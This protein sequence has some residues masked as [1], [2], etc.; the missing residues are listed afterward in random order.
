MRYF[1]IRSEIRSGARRRMAIPILI[2]IL[3]R[4]L[5][6]PGR[7]G[8]WSVQS[9]SSSH[10]FAEG[11]PRVP[12][13]VARTNT[14]RARHDSSEVPRMYP[15]F[16]LMPGLWSLDPGLQ[17]DAQVVSL[18]GGGSLGPGFRALN[19]TKT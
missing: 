5:S 16:P 12:F 19:R 9:T 11:R 2:L 7:R 18:T 4:I 14:T 15:Q 13:M 6:D 1:F 3:V 17:D 10:Q 8:G